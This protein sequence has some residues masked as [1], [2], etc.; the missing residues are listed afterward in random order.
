[1]CIWTCTSRLRLPSFLAFLP[2]Q[3]RRACCESP[4]PGSRLPFPD[5]HS[6]T[7]PASPSPTTGVELEGSIQSAEVRR[8]SSRGTWWKICWSCC[9]RCVQV[10][11]ALCT[12]CIN[13][14]LL[15]ICRGRPL[16]P[17]VPLSVPLFLSTTCPGQPCFPCATRHG[18]CFLSCS[19]PSGCR[20]F[21]S[22]STSLLHL[23]PLLTN[24]LT[25]CIGKG[26]KH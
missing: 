14:P 19:F 20:P 6:P 3:R 10:L 25:N 13:S 17:S 4:P 15:Q 2:A 26:N 7:R 12:V 5:E 23:P 16:I 21:F 18:T 11:S 22:P 9:G 24:L 8:L 1:M